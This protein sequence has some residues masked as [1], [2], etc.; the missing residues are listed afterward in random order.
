MEG[1]M[2]EKR[3]RIDKGKGRGDREKDE[4]MYNIRE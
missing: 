2:E 4:Y 1:R 3:G